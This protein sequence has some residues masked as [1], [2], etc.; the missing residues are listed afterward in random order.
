MDIRKNQSRDWDGRYTD[1]LP[2]LCV[3]GHAKG[4]HDAERAK[5]HGRV[6]Q[7]CHDC[8]CECYKRARKGSRS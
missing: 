3:C 5:Y 7:E 1:G 8:E 4:A 6:I 2:R